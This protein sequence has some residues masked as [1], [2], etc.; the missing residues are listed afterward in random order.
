MSKRARIWALVTV[1]IVLL[2]GDP[3][4]WQLSLGDLLIPVDGIWWQSVIAAI[5]IAL[6]VGTALAFAGARAQAARVLLLT[7]VFVFAVGNVGYIARDG[8]DRFSGGL[9]P[10]YVL[11]VV[12]LALAIRLSMVMMLQRVGKLP[13]RVDS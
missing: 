9:I 3:Y 13:Y 8:L 7:E 5:E 6:L 12:V 2:L 1:A 11:V 10:G 4:T